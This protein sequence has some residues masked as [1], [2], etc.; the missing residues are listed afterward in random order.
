MLN[1]C[2]IL[3]ALVLLVSC[4]ATATAPTALLETMYFSD[5]GIRI[6]EA[7]CLA[8]GLDTAAEA[9]VIC[10]LDEKASEAIYTSADGL[11]FSEHPV[12]DEGFMD[13]RWV[14]WPNTADT[15]FLVSVSE[16]GKLQGFQASGSGTLEEIDLHGDLPGETT[17]Q[18]SVLTDV[19]GDLMLLMAHA[20]GSNACVVGA[21]VE[22]DDAGRAVIGPSYE[23]GITCDPQS[24]FST[25]VLPGGRIRLYATVAGKV[26]SWIR[27]DGSGAF[28]GEAGVRV[29]PE[30]FAGFSVQSLSNPCCVHLADG[31]F[32]LYMTAQIPAADGT[33]SSAIVSAT[34]PTP[35]W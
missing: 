35:V 18:A 33:A 25:I 10:A 8:A 17:V 7:T 16:Q 11:V 21:S 2:T 3:L 27:E 1:R 15:W 31:R 9:V 6:E 23:T 34:T 5:P 13:P 12:R 19:S 22:L 26:M 30:D 20:I 29:K 28:T 14:K 32:R 4:L 24:S